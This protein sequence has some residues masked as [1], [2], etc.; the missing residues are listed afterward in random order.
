LE[1]GSVSGLHVHVDGG[2]VNG[3]IDLGLMFTTWTWQDGAWHRKLVG[4]AHSVAAGRSA[5]HAE[6]AAL[7]WATRIVQ[8]LVE[9]WK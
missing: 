8:I 3:R 6:C 9:R 7:E 1:G 4:Y 2:Y 5:F